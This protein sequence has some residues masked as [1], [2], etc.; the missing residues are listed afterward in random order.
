[1]PRLQT[2][3]PKATL[4]DAPAAQG[5]SEASSPWIIQGKFRKTAN[6]DT[7]AQSAAKIQTKAMKDEL[8]KFNLDVK[9]EM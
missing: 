4:S 7:S 1:M 5:S 9:K 3:S 6:N 2:L 8:K